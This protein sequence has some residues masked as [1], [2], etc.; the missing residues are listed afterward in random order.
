MFAFVGQV[1]LAARGREGFQEIDVATTI[2][3][4]AKWAAEP[5][6]V[7]SAAKAA[8][9]AVRQALN[10]PPGPVVFSAEMKWGKGAAVDVGRTK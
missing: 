7:A 4:L 2:G 9:E 3:G 10:G 5:T 8:G 6:D 1:E